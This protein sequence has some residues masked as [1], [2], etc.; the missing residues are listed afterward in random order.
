MNTR[1]RQAQKEAK[2]SLFLT[3]MYMIAWVCSAY[4]PGT[5]PGLWGF[6]RWFEAACLFLPPAFILFCWCIIRSQFK[7]ISLTSPDSDEK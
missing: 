7:C 6:P 5:K 4:L 1:F 2:L 3:V